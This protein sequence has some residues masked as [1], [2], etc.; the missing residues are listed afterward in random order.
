MFNFSDIK[1][2]QSILSN[3]FVLEEDSSSS[4]NIL[5][6]NNVDTSVDENTIGASNNST[7]KC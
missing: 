1:F 6:I 3:K 7:T 4:S 5:S 2:N